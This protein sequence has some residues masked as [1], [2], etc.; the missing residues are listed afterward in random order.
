MCRCYRP[1]IIDDM[2]SHDEGQQS[3][4]PDG[5]SG[6]QQGGREGERRRGSPWIALWLVGLLVGT[7]G[8][9]L[10][11][12]VALG[13]AYGFAGALVVGALWPYLVSLLRRLFSGGESLRG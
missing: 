8:G 12:D 5:T 11:D 6:P 9:R 7:V 4:G 2:E 3:S 13:L 1:A 10:I